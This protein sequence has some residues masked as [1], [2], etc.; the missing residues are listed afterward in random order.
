MKLQLLDILVIAVYVIGLALLG[1]HFGRKQTTTETY[2]VAKRSIPSWALGISLLGTLITSVTFIAYP[3]AAYGSNWSLLVPGFLALV[4]LAIVG[5]KVIPFYRHEVRMSAYEYFGKRFGRTARIY[6][7]ITFALGH[8]SKMAFVFYLLSLTVNSITGWS[9][10]RIILALGSVTILYTLHGGFEA[11]I[12][13]EVIQGILL[14]TGVLVVL[15]FL[16]FTTPGGPMA[17]VQVAA[18]HGKFSLGVWRLDFSHAT[19]PVLIIY[20]FFWYLQKYAADQQ[21]VQRYLVAKSDC[22]A[23]R[24][25]AFGSFLCVPIWTLF[26]LIGTALWS[27]FQ[28]TG[29]RLPRHI[30]KPDQVFPYFIGTHLPVGFSGLILA[31]LLGAAM[32]SLSSDLNSFALVGVEDLYRAFRPASNDAQR[33]RTGKWIVGIS[34]GL[35]ISSALLLAHTSGSALSLWYSVSAI[36]G[37]GLAGL[38]LLAYGSTRVH[39]TGVLAGIATS[40]LFTAW[41]SLT[42]PDKR[43]IDLGRWNFPWHD[44]MVGATANVVLLVVGYMASLIFQAA[45]VSTAEL[46]QI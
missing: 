11:V 12:W 33:L 42:L 40:L 10:D 44:Y 21:Y 4:I 8:L 19:L 25:V 31:A 39:R 35:C 43:V 28:I 3:G 22:A 6:S 32:C 2:F 14:W 41:A 9:I 18:Q 17:S 37:G 34:G 16:C 5:A 46:E 20:G 45:P 38:F 13:T 29:E 36:T 7:S 23:F 24:G 27:Y 26:M 15:L 1:L 30:A